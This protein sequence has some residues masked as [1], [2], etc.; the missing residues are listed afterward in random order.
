MIET[1]D[2]IRRTTRALLDALRS[3]GANVDKPS[4]IKCP[5]HEDKHASGATYQAEDGFF[6]FKC[7]AAGC[8]FC[9]DVFDVRAKTTGRSVEDQLSDL[10]RESKPAE[11]P[12]AKRFA[13]IDEIERSIFNRSA[14][15]A[16]T[17]PDTREPEMLVFRIELSG[18]K[19]FLQG[20]P[21][22]NGFVLEAP[23]KPW[24]IYN[25]TRIR[26]ATDIIVVEGEKCVHSLAA[27]GFVATTSP[28]GAGKAK[29]ADWSHLAGKNVWLWPD[30]DPVNESGISGGIE[31]MR[32]VASILE[33]L[34][35]RPQLRWINPTLYGIP[36]KGDVVDYI[37]DYGP[38]PEDQ[39]LAVRAI[40]ECA[41]SMGAAGELSTLFEDA[42]AGKIYCVPWP[43]QVLSI[44]TKALLPGTVTCICGD[45]GS[46]KSFLLLQAAAFWFGNDFKVALYEL[47]EDRPYHLKR[48]LA[49]LAEN[50]DL[51]E[52]EWIEAHPEESRAAIKAHEQ[53]ID[54]FGRCVFSAPDEQVTL[55]SLTAWVRQ[56]AS[57]GCRIIAIDPITA[58]ATGAKPWLDD[59][60]FLM[61]CKT[62]VRKH[63]ASLVLVTHPRKGNRSKIPTLDDLAGGAAYQRFSQT[64]L[65]LVRHDTPKKV[66]I[67]TKLGDT[68]STINR[69]IQLHK[70][71]NGRGAG[72]EIGYQ[73][74][75]KTLSF[76]ECGVVIEDEENGDL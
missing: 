59:L 4:A 44:N 29:H 21:D 8:G 41:D 50:A 22:G 15:F 62:I 33:R 40:M 17:N 53:F 56:M 55:E 18:G 72:L 61:E 45:P 10:R 34:E 5:F 65:W 51:T 16:Y 9:G 68:T 48:L 24:P 47:E 27:L 11:K 14:T 54:G 63:G 6:R 7:H 58:A 60:K 23:P 75:G 39:T 28:G 71:R 76:G 30:N 36:P 38:N 32:E 52:L 25:R 37:A 67:R 35:P 1:K 70:T 66:R 74:Y 69:A 43:W 26:V 73:F 49:Q 13:S 42:I 46:T 64:V 2:D 57:S 12:K 3:A 20:R 19:R 31:H